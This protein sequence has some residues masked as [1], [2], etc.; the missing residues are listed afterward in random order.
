MIST[1]WPESE[2]RAGKN[3]LVP[4]FRPETRDTAANDAPLVERIS[5]GPKVSFV[6]NDAR[7]LLYEIK[8]FAGSAKFCIGTPKACPLS[9]S[10]A[11]MLMRASLGARFRTMRFE[12]KGPVLAAEGRIIRVLPLRKPSR[13]LG[14]PV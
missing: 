2:G 9:R 4:A 8:P 5:T 10:S 14:S 12:R 13:M 6:F 1:N 11:V 3:P 7:T